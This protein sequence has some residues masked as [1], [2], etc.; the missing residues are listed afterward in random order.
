ASYS[1]FFCDPARFPDVW[2]RIRAAVRPGGR[3]AG[4]LL[5]ERDTWALTGDGSA[6]SRTQAEA[7]FEGWTVERFEE[8]ENDGEACSGPKHWHLFHVTAQAR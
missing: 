5:G 1:L 2:S 3:F 6:F 7:L 8:E 4:E